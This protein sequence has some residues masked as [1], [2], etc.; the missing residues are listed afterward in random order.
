MHN[1]NNKDK[2]NSVKASNAK[3]RVKIKA[4]TSL[5]NMECAAEV[6]KQFTS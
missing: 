1:M 5:I 2:S 3:R 4:A 6:K